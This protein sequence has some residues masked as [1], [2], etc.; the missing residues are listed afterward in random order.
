MLACPRSHAPPPVFLHQTYLTVCSPHSRGI[1][2]SEGSG[3]ITGDRGKQPTEVMTY[4]FFLSLN[5]C[6]FLKHPIK[7]H[8]FGNQSLTHQE[9]FLSVRCCPSSSPPSIYPSLE[10]LRVTFSTILLLTPTQEGRAV[11]SPERPHLQDSVWEPQAHTL[12]YCISRVS[13]SLSRLHRLQAPRRKLPSH[14]SPCSCM[15]PAQ[16][17]LS[18]Q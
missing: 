12:G 17:L 2:T 9:T 14:S 5:K 7:L 10:R 6:I 8:F 15:K 13:L 18:D 1:S 11:P 3:E 4:I 16:H